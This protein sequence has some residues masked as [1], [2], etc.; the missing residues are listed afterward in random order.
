ML[1]VVAVCQGRCGTRRKTTTIT[2]IEVAS[3]KGEPKLVMAEEKIK[4]AMPERGN[5]NESTV[6]SIYRLESDVTRSILYMWH[7]LYSVRKYCCSLVIFEE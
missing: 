3:K 6:T 1:L 2:N 5:G 4:M 7:E